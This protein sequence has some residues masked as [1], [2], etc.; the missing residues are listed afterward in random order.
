[1]K[2]LRILLT[3]LIGF[4]ACSYALCQTVNG[5]EVDSGAQNPPNAKTLADKY[6]I[7][8][9]ATNTGDLK[10]GKLNFTNSNSKITIIEWNVQDSV[11]KISYPGYTLTIVPHQTIIA[12]MNS[13]LQN[14]LD[15]KESSIQFIVKN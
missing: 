2:K 13:K 15:E 10:A 7:R 4:F 14:A 6:G 5:N 8:I 1:M 11:G 3:A 9:F 12:P